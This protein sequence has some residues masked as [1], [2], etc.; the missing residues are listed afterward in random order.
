[1]PNGSP[2]EPIWG[3]PALDT[4]LFLPTIL[5]PDMTLP[6]RL[7]LNGESVEFLWVVPISSAECDLKLKEGIDELLDPVRPV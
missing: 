4:F 2:P 5:A 3:S 7:R 6:D 1:M